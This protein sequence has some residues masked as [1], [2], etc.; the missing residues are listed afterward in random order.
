MSKVW[1]AIKRVERERALIERGQLVAE[2]PA[3]ANLEAAY[4]ASVRR[5]W[6]ARGTRHERLLAHWPALWLRRRTG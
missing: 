6:Q 1:E 3:E 4:V 2:R 5:R